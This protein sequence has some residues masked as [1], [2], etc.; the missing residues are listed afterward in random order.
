MVDVYKARMGSS[1]PNPKKC[2]AAV[3]ADYSWHQ[4]SR[5]GVIERDGRIWC[6]QHDPEAARER[7]EKQRA[8]DEATIN[9]ARHQACV[10]EWQAGAVE[11]LRKIA[12]G[13]NDPAGLAREFMAKEPKL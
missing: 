5:A 12:D 9:A 7:R 2:A 11:V 1:P 4:C 8:K 13:N 10:I 6:K 3:W